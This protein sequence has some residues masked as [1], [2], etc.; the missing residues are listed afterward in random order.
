MLKVF[1]HSAVNFIIRCTSLILWINYFDLFSPCSHKKNKSSMNLHHKYDIYSDSFIIFS[2]SILMIYK[3]FIIY[4]HIYIYIYIYIYNIY[5]IC[6]YIYIY[7]YIY[8]Y[9]YIIYIIYIYIYIYV[10][11][12]W[13]LN[14]TM[15][16]EPRLN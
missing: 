9:I 7:M 13:S 1:D 4:I 8:V 14:Q 15:R 12:S 6:I 3:I 5:I 10:Y 16:V 11:I 2:S